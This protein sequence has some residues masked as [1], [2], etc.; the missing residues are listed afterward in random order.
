MQCEAHIEGYQTGSYFK[1]KGNF[2]V[3]TYKRQQPSGGQP[4]YVDPFIITNYSADSA[5]G[6]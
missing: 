1:A 2:R 6:S 3:E 4:A 5:A